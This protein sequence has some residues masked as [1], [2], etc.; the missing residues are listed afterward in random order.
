MGLREHLQHSIF[1]HILCLDY[2]FDEGRMNPYA[3]QKCFSQCGHMTGNSSLPL[4]S[5]KVHGW[6]VIPPEVG[7]TSLFTSTC[8]SHTKQR[9]VDYYISVVDE[10]NKQFCYP[11]NPQKR[12]LPLGMNVMFGLCVQY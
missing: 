10:D 9:H 12:L 8:L 1:I 6:L 11:S 7:T 4:Q 3:K 2:H 5:W